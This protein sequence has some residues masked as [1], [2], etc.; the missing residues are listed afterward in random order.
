M[1]ELYKILTWKNF[2]IQN[3]APLEVDFLRVSIAGMKTPRPK[4]KL[5]EEWVSVAYTSTSLF[6]IK[7]S[8]DRNS[9][10]AGTW[11]QEPGGRS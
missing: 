6:I 10:R 2:A 7:R 9:H 1:F 11:R 4:S 5:G 3:E 8:Q